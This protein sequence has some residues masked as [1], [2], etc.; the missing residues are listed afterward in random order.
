[1]SKNLFPEIFSLEG[2]NALITGGGTGIG[3]AI[4]EAMHAAGA[5]VILVGRREKEL[6]EAAEKLGDR[7]SYFSQDI[8][9][10]SGTPA[11]IE[12]VTAS[13]G[14]ITCLVNNAGIQIKKPAVD[15][16]PEDW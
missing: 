4:A 8:S 7:A 6:R 16:T 1:M 10:S 5:R 15:T 14:P 2:E 9:Q 11:F 12:R 13:N 3:Y